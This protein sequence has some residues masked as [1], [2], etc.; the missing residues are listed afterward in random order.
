MME[1]VE[2]VFWDGINPGDEYVHD[3]KSNWRF[4]M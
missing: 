3:I 4:C 2:K 1:L